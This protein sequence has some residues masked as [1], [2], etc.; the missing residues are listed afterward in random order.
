MRLVV[1][2]SL[3]GHG[4]IECGTKIGYRRIVDSQFPEVIGKTP[5]I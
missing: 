3:T 1:G 4:L 2:L 5:L